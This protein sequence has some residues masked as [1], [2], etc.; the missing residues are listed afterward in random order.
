MAHAIWEFDQH[1]RN[2]CKYN[3]NLTEKEYSIYERMREKLREILNDN[4][5][6]IEL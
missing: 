4:D 3:E 5:I 6:I 2:E 1:L